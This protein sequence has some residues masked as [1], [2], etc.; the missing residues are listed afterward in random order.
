MSE[1]DSRHTV[2]IID[3]DQGVRDALGALLR[4]VGLAV[5]TYDGA[6]AFLDA[7][8]HARGCILTDVRMPMMSG[9]ELLGECE[10][11][12]IDMPVIVITGHADVDTAV[13]S[14]RSG[15][16]DFLEKPFADN[17]LI[18]AVN[19]T[20]RGM[21]SVSFDEA[22]IDLAERLSNLTA[23]ERELLPQFL[24]GCTNKEIGRAHDISYRT[25]ERHRQSAFEKLGVRNAAE[26]ASRLAHVDLEG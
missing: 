18:E 1:T 5:E 17:D 15:A 7:P 10:G 21:A 14:F 4:S 8:A 9:L 22:Q 12:G 3:D 6:Q 2:H 11:R 20:L 23:R 13:K 24:R 26:A 16:V 25:V 19:R